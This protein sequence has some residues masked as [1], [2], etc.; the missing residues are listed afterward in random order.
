MG[1][2]FCMGA[3]P[4]TSY[5]QLNPPGG[6]QAGKT[7]VTTAAAT[8]V[9]FDDGS[10]QSTASTSAGGINGIIVPS[11]QSQIS[12]YS[13]SGTTTT[14]A[15]A[16]GFSWNGSSATVNSIGTGIGNL[17]TINGGIGLSSPQDIYVLAQSSHSLVIGQNSQLAFVDGSGVGRVYL[18]APTANSIS[19]QQLYFFLPNSSGTAGQFMET[20]GN[21]N[22]SWVTGSGSLIDQAIIY[23]SKN[24]NDSNSGNNWG[25]AKLT[26]A[27]GINALPSFS[28][29]PGPFHYGTVYIGP[30]Q[31]VETNTPLEFDSYIRLEGTADTD[32]AFP[33]GTQIKLA[34]GRNTSLIGFT[35]GFANAGGFAHFS[36]IDNISFDGNAA[37]NSS[38]VP[39]SATAMV[40]LVDG[41][42]ACE[43]NNVDF[44]DTTS[45]ALLIATTAVNFS[46]NHCTFA[47][48]TAGA[49]FVEDTAG[50]NVISFYDTQIDGS[51]PNAITVRQENGDQ[52]QSNILTFVNLKTESGSVGNVNKHVIDFFPR[53]AG[54][55][56][57]NISILGGTLINTDGAGQAAIFEENNGGYPANWELMGIQAPGFT[58]AFNSAATGQQ[59]YGTTIKYMAASSQSSPIYA[60][61]PDFE[62]SGGASLQTGTGNPNSVFH[63]NVG[64][65]YLRTDGS[66][67]NTLYVKEVSTTTTGWDVVGGGG[68]SGTPAFPLNS[69]QFNST[70]T[71]NGSANFTTDGSSITVS[72]ISV[73]GRIGIGIPP[74]AGQSLKVL[75]TASNGISINGTTTNSGD[76]IYAFS[77]GPGQNDA[78]FVATGDISLNGNTGTFGQ[79]LTSQGNNIFPIWSTVSGGGTSGTVAASNQFNVGYYTNAGAT[80]TIGG[81]NNFTTDGSS[82]TASTFTATDLIVT[83]ESAKNF[84]ASTATIL[85]PVSILNGIVLGPGF[86]TN[87]G[88]IDWWNPPAPTT[89]LFMRWL[90]SNTNLISGPNQQR[91]RSGW[92][93]EDG[94]GN[95]KA[96]FVIGGASGGSL[97]LNTTGQVVLF[98]G[99]TTNSVTIVSSNTN[100]ASHSIVLPGGPAVSTNSFVNVAAINGGAA[101]LN[102]FDLYDS[103]PTWTGAATFNSNINANAF[104]ASATSFTVTGPNGFAVISS[105]AGQAALTEGSAST[106]LGTASGVESLW[107]D[108]TDHDLD[109]NPNNSSTFSVVGSSGSV[110]AGH[111]AKF[112]SKFGI[113]DAGAA[114]GTG[115]GGG[116]GVYNGTI[117]P[118]AQF[119]IPFYSVSGTTQTL[120]GN[121]QFTVDATSK[122]L[123]GNGLALTAGDLNTDVNGIKIDGLFG[124]VNLLAPTLVTSYALTFSSFQ[125]GANTFLKNDGSGN[126]S[127]ASG[128]G[129][130]SPG[131]GPGALQYYSAGSFA[132]SNNFQFSGSSATLVGSMTVTDAA[133]FADATPG[134]VDIFS[135]NASA[136]GGFPFL[137]MG[138]NNQ[139][140]QFV[141]KDL[142]P[143][144]LVNGVAPGQLG[145]GLTAFDAH[146]IFDT[147]VSQKIVFFDPSTAAMDF[148]TCTTCGPL[149]FFPNQNE[150]MQMFA[151]NIQITASSTTLSNSG[152]GSQYIQT[153]S[154]TALTGP[155]TL[156]VS[157]TGHISSQGAIP[158]ITGCT[159]SGFATSTYC[160][161]N[162]CTIT[163]GSAAT[164]CTITFAQKAT[165][166]PTCTVSEQTGSITNILSYTT[167]ATALTVS[168]TALTSKIDYHC[169]FKD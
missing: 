161:D 142:Q 106:V 147:T 164:G 63:G 123:V 104:N 44:R 75:N 83:T 1:V 86:G 167:T 51:G 135:H 24:G 128:T 46:C 149:A 72:T 67:G 130:T 33:N 108:S 62:L 50:G 157:T 78:V 58:S 31:F 99:S 48:N 45:Y 92:N 110:T 116:G 89:G 95:V 69:V 154:T 122:V 41:G 79:V 56:P 29:P 148:K 32:A 102:Y 34:N 5:V 140:N 165:N 119:Q 10:C 169:I 137:S 152:N 55:N 93:F 81:S 19:G 126:L 151:S 52:T 11:P 115:S 80:T 7:N 90:A 15:G 146:A 94:L 155:F 134:M 118:S 3:T 36:Q 111:C 76:A 26:V 101:N 74:A 49:V 91:T 143:L 120:I 96:S 35:T 168:Q 54:G 103:S 87:N 114:C 39:S 68:G 27:G 136:S 14:I 109:F 144:T 42:Y 23:V 88:T 2:A 77:T 9:C 117:L 82:V 159:G 131:G 43:F 70:G 141:F 22:L 16:S 105:S 40:R 65:L 112:S 163:P 100:S 158:T 107:A 133:G 66:A 28:G 30:G 160:N 47:N 53:T 162:A 37:N 21:G 12:Y 4:I 113:I 124:N 127:W 17:T 132:G 61:E 59:S 18:V 6:K 25:N 121:S 150:T 71:F 64:S 73:V 20:D 125:G 97:I 8:Q 166:V 38:I 98:D 139:A 145:V 153:N 129:S 138:S 84:S 13:A 57:F 60:Y 85:G 156:D